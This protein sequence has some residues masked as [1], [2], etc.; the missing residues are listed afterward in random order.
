MIHLGTVATAVV[1]SAVA[2]TL[3]GAGSVVAAQQINGRTIINGTITSAEV[4]NQALKS[5]DIRNGHVKF[6]DV[7][8]RIQRLLNKSGTAGPA[9]PAGPAGMNSIL[10]I[11]TA[12]PAASVVNVPAGQRL[13][14]S[15]TCNPGYV[16]MAGGFALDQASA[17][18]VA[19]VLKSGFTGT[20]P[21]AGQNMFN[22]WQVIA[23]NTGTGS[24]NMS[25]YVVC[26]QLP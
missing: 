13:S 1:G 21:T 7:S 20:Y 12:K 9:G 10:R 24:F 3:F 19:S 2:A 25:P 11:Y 6:R 5:R 17:G 16:A 26:A 22:G 15:A 14:T 18:A 8:D 4:K 23:Q